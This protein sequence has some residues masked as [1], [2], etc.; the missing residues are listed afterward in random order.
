[1]V[2]ANLYTVLQELNGSIDLPASRSPTHSMFQIGLFSIL[3]VW[4]GAAMLRLQ[5]LFTYLPAINGIF[6]RAPINLAS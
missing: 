4:E 1:M 5:V 2:Y 6:H 3:W